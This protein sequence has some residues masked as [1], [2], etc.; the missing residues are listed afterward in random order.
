MKQISLKTKI[1]ITA[2]V[3]IALTL[4]ITAAFSSVFIAN[5]SNTH[6]TATARSTVSDFSNRIDAWLTLEAQKLSV[7]ADDIS[8]CKFDTDNRDGLYDFLAEKINRLTEMYAIY[9][10]CPDN[11]SRYSDG[12]IPDAD[13]IVTER[14]WYKTAAASSEPIITDPYVDV[15]TGKMVITVAKAV[16]DADGTLTSVVAADMFLD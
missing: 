9:V 1:T 12:W 3:L 4:I 14:D 5:T 6:I 2:V 7:I 10:G 13:Y 16:H 8:Y 11:F 15:T